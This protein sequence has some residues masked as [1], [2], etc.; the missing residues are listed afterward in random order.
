MLKKASAIKDCIHF[1]VGQPDIAPSVGVLDSMKQAVDA[2][3]FPYTESLGILPLREK[4]SGFYKKHYGV[5]V[6]PSRVMLTVGTSG[7]FLIAYSV[8]LDIGERLAFTDPGYPCYKNY[9]YVLG[10]EPI[11]I[12][13]SAETS[14]QMTPRTVTAARQYKG[15]SDIFTVKPYR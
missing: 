6:D 14:Y 3:Q 12:P 1:E 5:D 15:C 4:I 10:I 2:G 7:A 13:V 8:L 9:S 11:M